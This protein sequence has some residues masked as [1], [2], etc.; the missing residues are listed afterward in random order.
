MTANGR[1][2]K[3]KNQFYVFLMSSDYSSLKEICILTSKINKTDWNSN[4]N[5]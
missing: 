2:D 5:L 1:R 4:A 3:K